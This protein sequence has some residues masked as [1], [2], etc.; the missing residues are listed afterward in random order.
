[1]IQAGLVALIIGSPEIVAIIGS[2][3]TRRDKATGLFAVAAPESSDLPEIVYS[4][5]SGSTSG[6]LA[7]AQ[8]LQP[9]RMQFSCYG[10]TYEE[11]KGLARALKK[12]LI[13]LNTT[14]ADGIRVDYCS[15][16]L[17]LDGYEEAPGCYSVPVD[18]EFLFADTDGD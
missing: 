13:G 17:E 11:A 8:N 14:F 15:L 7:G 5:I 10:Q 16:A 18:F 2:P 1:M 4:Q 3:S 12:I 9:C 6:M